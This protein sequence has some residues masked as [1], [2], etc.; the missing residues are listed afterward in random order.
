MRKIVGT[1]QPRPTSMRLLRARGYIHARDPVE[2]LAD[3]LRAAD[4]ARRR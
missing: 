2:D 1:I 3:L 4:R